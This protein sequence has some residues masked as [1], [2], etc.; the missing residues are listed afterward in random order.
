MRP[1]RSSVTVINI[2]NA[3]KLLFFICMLGIV[4]LVKLSLDFTNKDNPIDGDSFVNRVKHIADI[5]KKDKHTLE[6]KF[7][8][9]AADRKTSERAASP[10]VI[11]NRE[12]RRLIAKELVVPRWNDEPEQPLSSDKMGE[13]NSSNVT[14]RDKLF[15]HVRSA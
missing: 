11:F 2:K 13:V 9:I 4:F 5:E 7:V 14:D 15:T 1:Q 6:H 3:F 8:A 10:E 12:L